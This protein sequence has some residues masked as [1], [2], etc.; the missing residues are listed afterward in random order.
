MQQ[1]VVAFILKYYGLVIFVVE[2][3]TT[4]LKS[5]RTKYIHGGSLLIFMCF[6][7]GYNSEKNI[8][9]WCNN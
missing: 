8:L 4:V 6:Y 7:N 9:W 2:D 1:T 5:I 3:E